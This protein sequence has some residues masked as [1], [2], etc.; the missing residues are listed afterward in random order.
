MA[1]ERGL[2][3]GIDGGGTSTR[4]VL[5]DRNGVVLGRGE[6]GPGNPKSNGLELALEE[7]RRAIEGSFAAAHLTIQPVDAICLALAGA[8]TPDDRG[9]IQDWVHREKIATRST[10]VPDALAVLGGGSPNVVGIS[11]IAGTGS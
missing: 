5:A 8:G 7:V 1:P 2:I 9:P 10:V 3:L 4:A 11:L 6:A